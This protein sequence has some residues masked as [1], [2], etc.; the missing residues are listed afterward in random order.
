MKFSQYNATANTKD[1]II[2]INIFNSNYVKINNEKDIEHFLKIFNGQEELLE[3]DSMV[4]ALYQ[5]GY[6]I[7]DAVNEYELAKQEIQEQINIKSKT[8]RILLYVTDQCNFRC[9][10]CPEK[11]INN[12]F[13][14]K[15]YQG[16]YQ[17]IKR[18]VEEGRYERIEM[19]FFGGEPLI[20][21][22][23]IILFI[24]KLEMLKEINPSLVLYHHITTNGYLL[25]SEI[26]DKLVALNVNT[27]QI[28]LDGF[29][30][31]HDKTR[32][33][34][35]GKGSWNKIIKNLKYIN[36]KN[37]RAHVGIRTNYNNDNLETLLE[38]KK[39][40]KENF[41]NPKFE[42]IYEAVS[43]FSKRVPDELLADKYSEQ[44]MNIDEELN[45][46]M[47]IFKKGSGICKSAYQN[48]FTITTLGKIA[49]C[50][51]T[52]TLNKGLY[53]GSLLETGEVVFD[54]NKKDW[55]ENF[56]IEACKNCLIYPIC[57]ARACPA[58]KALQPEERSDCH[59]M[60]DD[61]KKRMLHF[62]ENKM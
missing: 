30:E 29:A 34:I 14:D 36:T 26:Y 15:H 51:N 59:M 35:D 47:N 8:L 44:S 38:F 45:N 5:N 46:S 33:L 37:D 6:I 39:W 7:D 2:L 12:Y 60:Q 17:F 1:G 56:E 10:Y 53:I 61:F 21:V 4:K 50:T 55:E 27:Y 19:S 57:C 22:D 54:D 13:S 23:K 42:F 48:N 32:P 62:A 31:T 52:Y 3:T 58:K 25:T 28:T 43:K 20:C 40:E 24:E 16:L 49:K 18:G 11:H 9:A 41:T